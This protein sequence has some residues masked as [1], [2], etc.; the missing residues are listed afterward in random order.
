MK[1]STAACTRSEDFLEQVITTSDSL[2]DGKGQQEK[3]TTETRAT[4]NIISTEA[5]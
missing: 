3:K 1:Y 2:K 5:K 4:K